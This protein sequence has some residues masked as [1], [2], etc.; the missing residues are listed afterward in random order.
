MFGPEDEYEVLD[1]YV[2]GNST[3]V[4]DLNEEQHCYTGEC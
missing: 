2:D 1:V 4:Y 3:I